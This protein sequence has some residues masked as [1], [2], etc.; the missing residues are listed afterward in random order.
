MFEME[1]ETALLRLPNGEPFVLPA[2]RRNSL[3]VDTIELFCPRYTPGAV[4]VHFVD[5]ANLIMLHDRALL[6]HL[7]V[8]NTAQDEVPDLVL[9]DQQCEQL[10]LLELLGSHGL[11]SFRRK[12]ELR[13][14]FQGYKGEKLYISVVYNLEDCIKNPY[15]VAWGTYIWQA[16]QPDQL[17][18]QQ[19]ATPL[20]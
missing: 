19:E 17:L 20:W 3:G 18:Y 4:V 6:T 9:Y 1:Q 15:E 7:K 8:P 5:V 13:T 12:Y 14:M 11:I 2:N 16:Q 10:V